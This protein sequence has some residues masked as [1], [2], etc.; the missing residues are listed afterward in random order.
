MLKR[1]FDIL[2]SLLGIVLMSPF[3]LVIIIWIILDSKG[4]AFYLQTRVGKGNRDFKI[5]KFRTMYSDS[6]KK[7]LLT[8]GKNDNRVTRAGT[9]LRKFKLDELPQLVN[10]LIGDMSFVGPRPEVRKYVE[11]YNAEQKRVLGV[12]PGITDVASIAYINEN[13]L[14]GKS[15]DPEATYINDVMPAKLRLNLEYINNK[16]IF[17]DIVV[18]FRTIGRIIS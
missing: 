11:M 6:D 1:G 13:E 3:F 14:L 4:G 12:K 8:V 16:N 17:K 10:V 9:F 15:S 18:I 5:F 7:G 2:F